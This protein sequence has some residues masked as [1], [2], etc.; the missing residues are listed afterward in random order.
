M[1]VQALGSRLIDSSVLNQTICMRFNEL[2]LV[3]AGALFKGSYRPIR[4][5]YSLKR[6]FLIGSFTKKVISDWLIY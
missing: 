2:L 3:G 5:L 1:Y 6:L 4:M